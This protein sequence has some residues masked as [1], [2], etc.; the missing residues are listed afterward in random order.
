MTRSMGQILGVLAAPFLVSLIA[1]A[2]HR[3]PSF[4]QSWTPRRIVAALL[5]VNLFF[6]VA[7]VVTS[8]PPR[9][10]EIAMDAMIGWAFS[11]AIILIF[12]FRERAGK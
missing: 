8:A 12:A 5:G 10:A 4:R 9:R 11:T 2:F 6:G 3:T 1:L 7:R